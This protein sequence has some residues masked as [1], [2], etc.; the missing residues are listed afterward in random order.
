[1]GTMQHPAVRKRYRGKI[2]LWNEPRYFG[3]IEATTE[4]P[5]IGRTIFVHR[6]NFMAGIPTRD[7]RVGREVEFEIGAPYKIGTKSQAVRVKLL[8]SVLAGA[9]ALGRGGAA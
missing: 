1:M 6:L 3:F 4:L 5:E 7:I 9:S 8:D 2:T